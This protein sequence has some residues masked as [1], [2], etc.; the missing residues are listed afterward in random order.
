MVC[1]KSRLPVGS[2]KAN[3]RVER[4]HQATGTA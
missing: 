4:M 2:L 1:K 3:Q